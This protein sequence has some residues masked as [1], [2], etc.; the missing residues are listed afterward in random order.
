MLYTFSCAHGPPSQPRRALGDL[1][2]IECSGAFI[3]ST[4]PHSLRCVLR[5]QLCTA[6]VSSHVR[7]SSSYVHVVY[8]HVTYHHHGAHHGPESVTSTRKLALRSPL[9]RWRQDPL[10]TLLWPPPPPPLRPLSPRVLSLSLGR[11]RGCL[12]ACWRGPAASWT[13]WRRWEE[14]R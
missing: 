11:S 12:G 8:H 14:G 6:T 10:T 9:P 4:I 1:A 2:S 13:T 7:L 3:T 5:A